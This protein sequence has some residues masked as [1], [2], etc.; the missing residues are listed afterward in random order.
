MV[1]TGPGYLCIR[2]DGVAVSVY[3]A[4]CLD[5]VGLQVGEGGWEVAWLSDEASRFRIVVNAD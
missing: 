5:G 2:P 1:H 4:G 3:V